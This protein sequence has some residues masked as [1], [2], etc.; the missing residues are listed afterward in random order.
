[1]IIGIDL[2]AYTNTHVRP[3]TLHRK[4]RFELEKCEWHETKHK[5]KNM[6]THKQKRMQKEGNGEA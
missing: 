5:T 6:K 4:H 2:H 1:M 3:Y